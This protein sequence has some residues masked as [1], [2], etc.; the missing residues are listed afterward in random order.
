MHLGEIGFL[1]ESVR[2]WIFA[3][4]YIHKKLRFYLSKKIMF[5]SIGKTCQSNNVSDAHKVKQINSLFPNPL[6]LT[7]AP[8]MY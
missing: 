4:L 5:F 8:Q 7:N 2:V 6:C 1:Y 3:F